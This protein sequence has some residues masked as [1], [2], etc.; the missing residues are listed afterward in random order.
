MSSPV[1]AVDTAAASQ[2]REEPAPEPPWPG[3]LTALRA[4]LD[5]IDDSLHD[6]LMQRAR[7]VEHVARS[8]KPAAFRPGRE[9]SM[10]RRLLGRH[11]GALPPQT[12]VR[13]WRE[14]LAGT[15]AMQAAVTVAVWAPD[16]VG[17]LAQIAREH[18]GALTPT[19]IYGD[20]AGALAAVGSGHATVAVLPVPSDTLPWWT[21]LLHRTPRLYV[22]ARLPFWAGRPDSVPAD[23]ALVIGA[24]A[25]DA[26][27]ADRTCMGL[28][29]RPD[30]ADTDISG[31][32][33]A[34]GLRSAPLLRSG[35]R[36][37]A[38]I[39]GLLTDDDPSL[40]RLGAPITT[41]TVLGGY[42][43]PVGGERA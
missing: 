10:L 42:A 4:E 19:R 18:F 28:D 22:I 13:I 43:V 31:A 26:S 15:T 12:I 5:R 30:A 40:S 39:E 24:S 20:A 41:A 9:A 3:G 27:G 17:S 36:V 33:A 32:L 7:V 37:L 23:P 6:L 14:M 35:A 8:G 29:V 38:D 21:M 16:T 2:A 11:G 25:P 1:S 34:A